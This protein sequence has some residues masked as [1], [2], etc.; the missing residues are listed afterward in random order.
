MTGRALTLALAAL[1]LAS[2]CGH[3]ETHVAMLRKPAPPVGHPVELYLADQ[4]PP[5]RPMID[6]ALVQAVGFGSDSNAEDVV[7]AL[8]RR[9]AALGCDAVTRVY[10]D[11]GYSRAHA[12]GVCV[13]YLGGA[14]DLTPSDAPLLPPRRADNPPPPP[15]RPAPAPRLEPFPSSPAKQGNQ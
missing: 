3:S 2:G 8:T 10:V 5:P 9:A 1:A 4:L 11:V 12:A 6:I 14:A 15:I 7:A 13:R